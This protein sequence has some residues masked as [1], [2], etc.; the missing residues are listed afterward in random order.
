ME[1]CNG[2]VVQARVTQ[3]TGG[4]EREADAELMD[5]LGGSRR[6]TLGA[7]RN[8]EMQGIVEEMRTR[9]VTRLK[10]LLIGMNGVNFR[11][12]STAC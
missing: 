7:D 8:Y 6:L 3:A 11:A 5:A 1:K 9:N 12:I 4:A 10:F 2:L